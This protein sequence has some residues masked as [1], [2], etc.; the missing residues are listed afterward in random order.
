MLD[1]LMVNDWV[2]YS[3][4]RWGELA[5]PNTLRCRVTGSTIRGLSNKRL[6]GRWA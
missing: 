3:K 1:T 2:V 4:D 6:D 5:N